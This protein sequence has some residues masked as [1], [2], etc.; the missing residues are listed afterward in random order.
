MTKT[1][2]DQNGPCDAMAHLVIQ[3]G[4]RDVQN[5]P[6]R[7]RKQPQTELTKRPKTKT[8][9]DNV[10]NGLCFYS[11]KSTSLAVQSVAKKYPYF[12]NFLS[13]C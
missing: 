4:P 5:G 13:N 9:H 3:N 10:E 12:Y 6:H 11:L 7:G 2:Q 1:A 8:A